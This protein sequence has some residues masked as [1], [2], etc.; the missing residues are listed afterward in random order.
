[1]YPNSPISQHFCPGEVI[2]RNNCP[3][4][5][6]YY[7]CPETQSSGAAFQA[8]QTLGCNI[9]ALEWEPLH[10][11]VELR[12]WTSGGS[13]FRALRIDLCDTSLRIAATKSAERGQTTSSWGTSRSMLAAINGGYFL[14]SGYKPDGCV[15]FGGG[16]EWPDSKDTGYRSYIAFGPGETF[17]R[18]MA[19][20]VRPVTSPIA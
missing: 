20:M 9:E 8:H 11:G 18:E 13:R 10:R 5:R 7:I 4:N 14:F 19:G 12:R 16:V 1:M 17:I 6:R 3:A 15:A 2:L